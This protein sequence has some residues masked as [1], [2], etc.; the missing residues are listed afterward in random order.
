[1]MRIVRILMLVVMLGVMFRPGATVS[2]SALTADDPGKDQAT[3]LVKTN[4]HNL[5][6]ALERWCVDHYPLD[7]EGRVVGSQPNYPESISALVKAGYVS[8]GLAPNPLVGDDPGE[9]DTMDVPP[10]WNDDLSPGNFTYLLCD[11]G[12]GYL[13]IG[14]GATR[15]ACLSTPRSMDGDSIPDGVILVLG[16]NPE[17]MDYDALSGEGKTMLWGGR[18]F[19]IQFVDVGD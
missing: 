13:L 12:R 9:F 18:M 8:P 19:R 17:F 16:S 11:D 10:I 15:E 1:M 7:S 5:Q 6:L 4:L 2:S 14:Y 3:Q